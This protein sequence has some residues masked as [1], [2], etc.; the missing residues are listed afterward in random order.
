MGLAFTLDPH[1]APAETVSRATV[2]TVDLLKLM[3]TV[4]E[5]GQQNVASA[6]HEALRRHGPRDLDARPMKW[7]QLAGMNGHSKRPLETKQD[8]L[9]LID[10]AVT[11][12]Q[13]GGRL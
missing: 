12:A 1:S 6:F 10:D 5:E 9:D 13:T 8:V 2:T 11:M 4:V 3:R 7:L